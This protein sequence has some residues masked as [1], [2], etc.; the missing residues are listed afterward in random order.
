MSAGRLSAY[1][2]NFLDAISEKLR[3]VSESFVASLQ[4]AFAKP[5]LQVA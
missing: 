3:G 2:Q 4:A 5:A 1:R